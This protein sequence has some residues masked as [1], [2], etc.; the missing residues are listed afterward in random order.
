[1]QQITEYRVGRNFIRVGDIVKV[2]GHPTKVGCMAR[3]TAIEADDEGNPTLLTVTFWSKKNGD[4]HSHRGKWRMLEPHLISKVD[5]KKW[6][7]HRA[8]W[9]QVKQARLDAEGKVA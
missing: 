3:L 9:P 6:E 1:M 4:F 7:T 5:Q 8:D 2:D